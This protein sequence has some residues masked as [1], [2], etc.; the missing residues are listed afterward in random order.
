M[1]PKK[2]SKALL[3]DDQA[4]GERI[5][6]VLAQLKSADVSDFR[7]MNRLSDEASMTIKAVLMLH[8]YSEADANW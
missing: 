8:G 6:Q 1:S 3:I 7:A 5:K 4:A 2:K